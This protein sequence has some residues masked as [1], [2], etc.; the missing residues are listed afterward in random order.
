MGLPLIALWIEIV[1][2]QTDIL[3]VQIPI[4]R[5]WDC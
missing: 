3:G 1:H 4:I 5:P 2:M